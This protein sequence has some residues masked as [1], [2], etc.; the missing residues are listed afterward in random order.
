MYVLVVRIGTNPILSWYCLVVIKHE[1][2]RVWLSLWSDFTL[3]MHTNYKTWM[4]FIFPYFNRFVILI[5]LFLIL[6]FRSL[7]FLNSNIW[8]LST[9]WLPILMTYQLIERLFNDLLTSKGNCWFYA[10][11][12]YS[13]F[14]FCIQIIK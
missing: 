12:S 3:T 8:S 10:V 9:I 13:T 2:H 14:F 4:Q 5:P 11:S 6:Q 7:N 1:P